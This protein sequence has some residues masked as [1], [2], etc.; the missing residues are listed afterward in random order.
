MPEIASPN[1]NTNRDTT[2]RKEVTLMIM[3]SHNKFYSLT[4]VEF[5]LVAALAVIALVL[6]SRYA[7]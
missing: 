2:F 4:D 1:S 3:Q 5:G 7:W 6:A